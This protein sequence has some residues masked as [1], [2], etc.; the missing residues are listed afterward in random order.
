MASFRV[1]FFNRITDSYGRSH[2]VCQRR[3]DVEAI[4][5]EQEALGI[6]KREFARVERVSDWQVRAREVDCEELPQ[7]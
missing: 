3:I 5:D 7:G 2:R 6:A 4:A 1:G